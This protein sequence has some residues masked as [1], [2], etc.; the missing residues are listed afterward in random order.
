LADDLWLLS[1]GSELV[2]LTEAGA[3]PDRAHRRV[4]DAANRLR[5]ALCDLLTV[6]PFVEPLVLVPDDCEPGPA[7]VSPGLVRYLLTPAPD[8][9]VVRRVAELIGGGHLGEGWRLVP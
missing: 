3:D 4:V 9:L 7:E 5:R 2:L 1:S 8:D 6:A